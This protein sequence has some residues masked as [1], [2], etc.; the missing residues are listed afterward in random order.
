MIRPRNRWYFSD[1][2]R[3][4]TLPVL[5]DYGFADTHTLA[6]KAARGALDAAKKARGE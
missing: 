6:A 1:R 3:I 2:W 5:T 4:L